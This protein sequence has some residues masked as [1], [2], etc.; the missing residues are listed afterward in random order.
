MLRP[1]L[2]VFL[3]ATTWLGL[4]QSSVL[5]SGQWYKV[6][7]TETGIYKIDRPM[8]LEMGISPE[9]IDA[10]TFRIHGYGGGALPQLNETSRPIDLP[11]NAIL[12]SGLEDGVFDEEDYI[13]FFGE[14]PDLLKL[15]EQGFPFYE[16][17]I[18]SDTSYY[19]L[20]YAGGLGLGV[21]TEPAIE[22]LYQSIDTYDDLYVI[23]NNT[24]NILKKDIE[25]G[26]SGR[27]WYG[28]AFQLNLRLEIEYE[29][30]L[31][32]FTGEG[33][34]IFSSL[35]QSEGPT[36]FTL[37]SNDVEVGEQLLESVRPS[38]EAPYQE[39][40][41]HHTDTFNISTA[42]AE[43]LKIKAVFN[44]DP[45]NL[46]NLARLDKIILDA[47]R[48]L[49][50]LENQVIFQS[51][52]SLENEMSTYEIGISENDL[53]VWN[54]SDA[55]R[56]SNI[57]FTIE[58]NTARF[59]EKS[60]KTERYVCFKG[61]DFPAPKFFGAIQN[62]NIQ[63]MSPNDGI[64]ITASQFLN[65]ANRLADF[66]RQHDNLDIAVITTDQIY[67]E[68]SSGRQDVSA[69]RDAI[70]HYWNKS[71]S[72]KYAL[73]FGDCSYDY[74][75]RIENNTNYVPTYESKNSVHPIFSYSSDDFFGF[76]EDDEGNWEE[77]SSGDHTLEVGIGRLPVKTIDEAE[78]IVNKIIRYSTSDRTFGNWKNKVTYVVDDGDFNRHVRD[79]EQ[80]SDYF[81]VFEGQ[82]SREKLYLDAFEQEI[83]ASNES[84][85]IVTSLFKEAIDEGTF[86]VNYI[87]HGNE[88]QWMDENV[89]DEE[90]LSQLSNRFQL[91]IFVTATCQFGRYDDPDFF[92]GSER[93][94]LNPNGGAIAL[95]TTTRPVFASSNFLVNRAFH[96]TLFSTEEGEFP[97][98]GDIIRITKNR[99]LRGPVNRNF[100]LL[101]DPFLRLNYPELKVEIYE[102][103][104][105]ET[106]VATDTLSALEQVFLKGRIVGLDGNAVNN[107]NGIAE[108]LLLDSE[109]QSRTLGQE[110]TP[111][112]YSIQ[113]NALFNGIVSVENGEFQSSFI[114]TRNTSY[115][116]ESGELKVY[117]YD[118][119]NALDASGSLNNFV[120]GGTT[121]EAK[122]DVLGPD[123]TLY[124]NNSD[125]VNGTAIPSGS[126]LIAEL[127]DEN[128]INIS[129]NGFNQSIT[130]SIDEGPAILANDK[131][132]AAL[133]SYQSGFVTFPL[134]DI[135]PGKHSAVLKV[136]DLY[137]NSTS[138]QVDFIVSDAGGIVL[139][140]VINYPNPVNN[141]TTFSFVHNRGGEELEIKIEIIDIYGGEV[142]LLEFEIDDTSSRIDDIYWNIEAA[143]IDPG[144]YIYRIYARSTLDGATGRIARK[145]IVN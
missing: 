99:S 46:S 47:K 100:S 119:K 57:Q 4:C 40:G 133:D 7:I 69:I 135:T 24:R 67:N 117:A 126:M 51:A 123:I 33:I 124:I 106:Q 19:F 130:I 141:E 60:E 29:Y 25:R 58:G 122:S 134:D 61:S 32:G 84:S 45:S 110:S 104:G 118:D 89:L 39:R 41:V 127:F 128:G 116:F 71:S 132:S 138:K 13:L 55:T 93:L 66:H 92:S 62:Q 36:S 98:L 81:R 97:R 18:Y 91:P 49:N 105:K 17:N 30:D 72:F 86:V 120:L 22:G 131:Y 96:E 56:P 59:N 31:S 16:G 108:I 79:A 10:K 3:C 42:P 63:A 9:S 113:N 76:M 95:L 111:I 20:T 43:T 52:A 70:R 83:D 48:E 140:E 23:E 139:T 34:L 38:I 78:D 145:L 90:G 82:L 53:Q 28:E 74:K 94:L 75:S 144:V 6:G 125:F 143:A 2:I 107:F 101:G 8:L 15:N 87:G 64:V 44:R 54:I 12:R 50:L 85:P 35:S 121:T 73:F 77:S 65:E 11:E 68:F 1:I 129:S 21:Q 109:T 102:I 80:L 142:E 112:D 5:S 136:W 27:E 137:N 114:I 26:G 88:F 37:S 14:R 115:R 103:N